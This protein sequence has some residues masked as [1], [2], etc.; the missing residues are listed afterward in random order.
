MMAMMA[1]MAMAIVAVWSRVWHGSARFD[2]VPG[3][4]GGGGVA[5]R[6]VAAQTVADGR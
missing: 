1:V 6:R 3:Y 5:P 4:V 2:T